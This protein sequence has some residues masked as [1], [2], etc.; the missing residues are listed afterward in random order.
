MNI[1]EPL[2]TWTFDTQNFHIEC[3]EAETSFVDPLVHNQDIFIAISLGHGVVT[4]VT[5]SVYRR[6]VEVGSAS[7]RDCHQ[8]TPCEA[9]GIMGMDKMYM[10]KAVRMAIKD[11]RKTLTYLQDDLPD[12]NLRS[13]I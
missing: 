13:A 10:R 1:E 8:P 2:A 3:K 4:N 6:G 7:V 9:S 12:L 5:A 11:A